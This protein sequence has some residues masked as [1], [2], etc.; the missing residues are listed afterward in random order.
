MTVIKKKSFV[1]NFYTS[2]SNEK[3]FDKLD[4]ISYAT[5]TNEMVEN[6]Y[7]TR[8]WLKSEKGTI[9]NITLQIL[10]TI[11]KQKILSAI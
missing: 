2:I 4:T 9:S 6:F 7:N 11:S 1:A 3:D 10:L 5:F 8:V